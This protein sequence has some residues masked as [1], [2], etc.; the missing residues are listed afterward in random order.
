MAYMGAHGS[1][2]A[3]RSSFRLTALAQWM[4]DDT[5]Y[6]FL[7]SS[8]DVSTCSLDTSFGPCSCAVVED[9]LF[10][11]DDSSQVSETEMSGTKS[12]PRGRRPPVLRNGSGG[13]GALDGGATPPRR[14]VDNEAG[15]ARGNVP[16]GN[17][18]I[19]G[20][21]TPPSGR[22]AASGARPP[23]I[24]SR[25]LQAAQ[26]GS[27][28]DPSPPHA[29][30]RQR[31]M[32][33]GADGDGLQPSRLFPSEVDEGRPSRGESGT[34]APRRASDVSLWSIMEEVAQVRTDTA[35]MLVALHKAVMREMLRHFATKSDVQH[36]ILVG[37]QRAGP[38]GSA[39]SIGQRTTSHTSGSIVRE[40]PYLN[41]FRSTTYLSRELAG[42]LA[43]TCI[44]AFSTRV[45]GAKAW[46]GGG[47]GRSLSTF[48]RS[49]LL[50]RHTEPTPQA[51]STVF[52]GLCI[53]FF[54]V[55]P[56]LEKSKYNT[57]LG[58]LY[59]SFLGLVI[60]TTIVRA[61]YEAFAYVDTQSGAVVNEANPAPSWV[62]KLR[63]PEE[64]IEQ[65]IDEVRHFQEKKT[66][67]GMPRTRK[68]GANGGSPIG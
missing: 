46:L 7:S 48:L 66:L 41:T 14:R 47:G 24:L 54:S 27:S 29:G 30:R 56:Y 9:D 23:T 13:T 68:R 34:D 39:P 60:Y 5:E 64:E 22:R 18:R 1:K 32:A 19:V 10:S 57:V 2:R 67:R 16:G 33:T 45:E 15:S 28:L 40:V 50:L 36:A 63:S 52:S 62:L 44:H 6:G 59:T 53:L 43:V 25:M 31:P 17:G 21:T 61:R 58:R 38:G 51:T 49:V 55:P 8:D 3:R 35:R 4:S 37:H 12:R 11:L 20:Q 42:Q 65:V 26:S